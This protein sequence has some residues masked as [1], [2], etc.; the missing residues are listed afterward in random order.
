MWKILGILSL[1][2]IVESCQVIKEKADGT[3]PPRGKHPSHVFIET[4]VTYDKKYQCSGVLVSENYV[5]TAA[6]CVLGFDFINVHLYAYTLRDV[7]E[8]QREIY[9]TKTAQFRTDYDGLNYLNDVALIKLP[10]TL[11]VT[12]KPYSIAKFPQLVDQLTEGREGLTVGWGL[13]DFEDK[14]AA[15]VIN[16]VKMKVVSEEKCRTAYPVWSDASTY[17]GRIC[18][19]RESGSNCISDVGSPFMID[20]VVFGIQSFGQMEACESDEP[21]GIQEVRFHLEWISQTL[22][23]A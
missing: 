7:F 23:L 22:A 5:L 12:G 16:E 8:P 19:Q 10:V 2:I 1:F 11:N 9:K 13:L 15:K 18:I 20:D 4:F 17:G 6:K 3:V 14:N 21:N